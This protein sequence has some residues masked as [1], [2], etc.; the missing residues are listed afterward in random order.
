MIR[1]SA[2]LQEL[3]QPFTARHAQHVLLDASVATG[4]RAW[5]LGVARHPDA[6]LRRDGHHPVHEVLDA[7]PVRVRID[8]PGDGVGQAAVEIGCPELAEHG[9]PAARHLTGAEDAE[10]ALVVLDR[11]HADAG[12]GLDHPVY[13]VDVAVSLRALTKHERWPAVGV[14]EGRPQ[15]GQGHHVHLEPTLALDELLGLRHFLDEPVAPVAR[16]LV[17]RWVGRISTHPFHAVAPEL[18]QRLDRARAALRA[19][20]HPRDPAATSSVSA[21]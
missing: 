17:S 20:D 1:A 12:A 6:I 11:G 9:P 14:D 19:D 2:Q 21:G 4:R 18:A 13:V 15:E 7:L 10:Q 16:A 8:F 5:V 3:E